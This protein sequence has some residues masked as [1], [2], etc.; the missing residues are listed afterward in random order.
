MFF[1]LALIAL[2]GGAVV[3]LVDGHRRLPVTVLVLGG[4]LVVWTLMGTAGYSGLAGIAIL[5]AA[6]WIANQAD[7]KQVEHNLVGRATC[8][9]VMA[10]VVLGFCLKFWLTT[11]TR[12]PRMVSAPAFDDPDPWHAMEALQNV[13]FAALPLLSVV[14]FLLALRTWTQLRTWRRRNIAPEKHAT[15]A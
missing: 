12:Q 15:S 4:V 5:A 13:Y 2:V 11:E 7:L 9:A 8:C 6:I 3:A 14:L 10:A 1:S